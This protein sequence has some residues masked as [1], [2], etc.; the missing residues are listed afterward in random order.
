MKLF[1]CD[2]CQKTIACT[3]MVIDAKQYDVCGKCRSSLQAKLEGRGEPIYT[4]SVI[5]PLVVPSPWP[6]YPQYPP[7]VV[8]NGYVVGETSYYSSGSLP[9]QTFGG[10]ELML[11]ASAAGSLSS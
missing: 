5:H 8:G 4:L 7:L 6:W 11:T 9:L 3:P 2:L 1:Q 10:S